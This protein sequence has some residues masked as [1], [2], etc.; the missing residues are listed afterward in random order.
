[1]GRTD[2][3]NYELLNWHVIAESDRTTWHVVTCSSGW[4]SKK[5]GTLES[6]RRREQ[7]Q[8]KK[9]STH[10]DPLP[11]FPATP[12][13]VKKEA[14]PLHTRESLKVDGLGHL[15]TVSVQGFWTLAVS[16]HTDS[17]SG[18]NIFAP[19]SMEPGQDTGV[20]TQHI[21]LWRKTVHER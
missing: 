16:Y 10:I 3:P 12:Q 7:V 5:R 21:M 9:P 1:M 8:M 17:Q 4:E 15:L 14:P 6:R 13:A 20:E 11:V 19:K 2:I 18:V